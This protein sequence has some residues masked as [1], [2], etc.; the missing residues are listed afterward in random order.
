[1]LTIRNFKKILFAITFT[2]IFL[3]ASNNKVIAQIGEVD[4]APTPPPT[5]GSSLDIP[6]PLA[7]EINVAPEIY[8]PLDE[9]LYI[10]GKADPKSKVELFFE[11]PGSNPVRITV[12]ANSGGEWFLSQKLE[13]ASGEWMVR[14]RISFDPPSD[15]SNPR[16]IQSRVTGFIVGGVR[17]K[18]APIA[19]ALV[20][21][22]LL[23]GGFLLYAIMRARS[24]RIGAHERELQEGMERH[25]RELRENTERH[26]R[27]L[28]ETM[29]RRERDLQE[30]LIKMEHESRIKDRDATALL[31]E[32]HFSG[33]R[34][35]VL[36]ELEHLELKVSQGAS[37]SSDEEEHRAKLLSNL[38]E[39]EEAITKKLKEIK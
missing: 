2:V 29:E 4:V 6:A 18:Y 31:L 34:E 30:S 9:T 27:E 22:F 17:V 23:G 5:G 33:I 15:W 8:Y 3:L 12:D 35:G 16:I 11:K 14:A 13:L 26:E 1:M 37:L 28:R 20:L 32:Q 36:K 19:I 38:R 7:P 21:L 24:V 25:E 39:A 10:E